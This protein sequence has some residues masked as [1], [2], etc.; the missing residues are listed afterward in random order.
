MQTNE[1]SSS[2]EFSP[3]ASINVTPFVDVVL[4]LLVIFMVTAPMM[5]KD[6]LNLQL[7]KALQAEQKNVNETLGVAISESGQVYLNAEMVSEVQ[8]EQIAQQSFQKNSNISAL[9]SADENSKH[10]D[11]VRVIDLLKKN[12][13]QKFALQV[14]RPNAQ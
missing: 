5:M 13:I 7:P 9:I 11:L 1:A 4:V 12:G 6:I 8:F 14:R 10:S 3:M 2:E